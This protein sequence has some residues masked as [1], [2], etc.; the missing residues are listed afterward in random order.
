MRT[1]VVVPVRNE[2]DHTSR[3]LRSLDA[4]EVDDV[5]VIDNESTDDTARAIR[6]WQRRRHHGWRALGSKLHRQHMR[7]TIYEMWNAGFSR[8]LRVAG[9][10]PFTNMM[11]PGRFEKC[12]ILI[13]NN[14]IILPRGA[15]ASLRGLLEHNPDAWVA[16]PD[17]SA[18]WQTDAAEMGGASVTSGVY[19]DGGMFGACFMLA[20]H[21]VPWT[22]LITDLSYEWW[23]G[24][25]HLA[26]MIAQHG[27]Q[28][29]RALGVPVLHVNE[30]TCR[31]YPQLDQAKYRDRHRWV[32]RYQRSIDD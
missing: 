22:P 12:Y 16:Y 25:N 29:L 17:Y 23:Y 13:S 32:T 18:P 24:D 20:G 3:F 2:W 28:Q 26:E 4:A 19:G 31:H 15:I 30:A 5:L 11:R 1:F 9:H 8:A 7:G 21:L 27:G 6:S 10:S 14:D